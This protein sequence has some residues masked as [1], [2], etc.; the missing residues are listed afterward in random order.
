M[1][2]KP[3]PINVN[4][5]PGDGHRSVLREKRGAV[6]GGRSWSCAWVGILYWFGSIANRSYLLGLGC[7]EKWSCGD[8]ASSVAPGLCGAWLG[9]LVLT[10]GL[11]E[12]WRAHV[13]FKCLQ[14]LFLDQTMSW[15]AWSQAG[16]RES[17]L[18]TFGQLV[19]S[20]DVTFSRCL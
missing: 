13:L 7:F 11:T 16:S 4:C 10:V 2:R 8:P 6:L 18:G 1:Q 12:T 5:W 14:L 20:Q 3:L 19:E 17:G 9:S 15:C